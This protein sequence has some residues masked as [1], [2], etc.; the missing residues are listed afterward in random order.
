MEA[1]PMCGWHCVCIKTAAVAQ[2]PI[3]TPVF[4]GGVE[5]WGWMHTEMGFRK[6]FPEPELAKL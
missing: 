5:A 2:E 4:G 6:A 3:K 1:H